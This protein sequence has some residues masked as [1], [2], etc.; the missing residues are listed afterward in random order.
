MIDVQPILVTGVPR[1]GASM[2]AGVINRCGAF[3][4]NMS[5]HK[6]VNENDAVKEILEKP[7]LASIWADEMGQYPLPKKD[8]IK[9]PLN[10]KDSVDE[11]FEREG[12]D[13]GAWFYKSSRATLIWQVWHNAYPHAKWVIVRRRTADIVE[14][15]VKT[16][17]MQAFKE[18]KKCDAVH[19]K[20]EREGWLW[21]VHEYE[22]KF[23]EMITEGLNCRVIYPERL[24]YG[25]YS[26]L[27]ETL[28]WLKLKW[29]HSVFNYIDPLL[30]TTRKKEKE[31]KNG[32]ISNNR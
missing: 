24:V 25:D 19:V 12:Y 26:Q 4:G 8:Q 1:S 27:Y 31:V 20:D 3:G 10:W 13:T 32:S 23:V 2:I 17:Y 15:C 5:G 6:G 30:E 21:F 16:G 29:K 7:Y 11:I 14:S 9:V 22:K 18:K 28:D